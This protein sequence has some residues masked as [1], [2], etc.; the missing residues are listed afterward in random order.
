MEC[1]A[2]GR[3]TKRPVRTPGGGLICEPCAQKD[4]HATCHTCRRHRP[5]ERRDG[6]GRALC[7]SCAANVPVTHACPGCA[8]QTPGAGAARCPAC[9]LAGR[10]AKAVE[11]EAAVLRQDWVRD[12][13]VAF[14]GW[15]GLRRKRGD[16][17]KHIG[18]YARFFAVI[19]RECRET[20][21]VTQARLVNLYGAE[22]LRRGFQVV[23]FLADRLAL[24]W[25][26]D[27]VAAANERRRVADVMATARGQSWAGDLAAYRDHLAAGSDIAP[28]T[29]RMYISAAAA[30]LRSSGV[31]AAANLTQRHLSRHLRRLPGRRTNLLRF[32]SWLSSKSAQ[33]FDAGTARR[34]PRRKFERSVI[35]KAETLLAR[36]SAA[37]GSRERRALVAAVIASVHGMPLKEVLALR[38]ISRTMGSPIAVTRCGMGVELAEPLAT[39][40][41]GID[42]CARGF[43]F[44]GRNGIQSLT[45]SAVR[46]HIR[47]SRDRRDP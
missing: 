33:G 19:D 44:Q 40:F 25:D 34:T 24:A 27:A 47:T 13:F 28:A 35:R 1:S 4:T 41:R 2:C 37:N 6:E 43:A 14:C 11:V 20:A 10:V 30:L 39:A 42:A 36:L 21:E 32:L 38:R 23:S 15:D 45:A 18:A 9:E 8:R 12:L 22:G 5:V 16:M 29:A 31:C 46:H 17:P 7:R 26:P 3:G